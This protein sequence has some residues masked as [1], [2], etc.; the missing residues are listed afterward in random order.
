MRRTME[1][2]TASRSCMDNP[3]IRRTLAKGVEILRAAGID[4]CGLDSEILLR[5][6][7][8]FDRTQLYV[9]F[10][11]VLGP[12]AERR[13]CE[14]LRRRSRREPIAYI[15]ARKEFWSLEFLVTPD[16]LIPRPETER[17]VEVAVQCARQIP[18]KSAF[19][20]LD[21]GTG[22][23]VIPVCLGKELS[24]VELWSVDHCA[25]ALA[26]AAVNARRHG[27]EDKIQFLRADMREP[28]PIKGMCFDLIVSNP[29][30]VPSRELEDL[31]P[32]VRNWE[33][34]T[35]LDGG[36]EGMDYY[37]HIIAHADEHLTG[38]GWIVVEIGAETAPE[39]IKLF[40][41]PANY[42]PVSVF[43]DYAGKDRVIAACKRPGGHWLKEPRGG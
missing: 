36:P 14:L 20:V 6:S 2:H 40:T 42:A 13:F 18:G 39:I 10:D 30:Y 38:R 32:D 12:A 34:L 21:L 4:T 43:Q 33:P 26:V 25:S 7:L 3:T 41:A 24:A 31:A 9:A 16:V 5:E 17:L 15:L 1:A 8:G 22:S 35:A 11:S 28:L 37:R 27:V 23:G 19:R 29:P